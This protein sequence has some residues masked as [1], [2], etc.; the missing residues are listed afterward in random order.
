LKKKLKQTTETI[1]VENT[2]VIN[3]TN[4]LNN[5]NSSNE[6]FGHNWTYTTNTESIIAEYKWDEENRMKEAVSN[7]KTV[8]FLYNA[9]G[10]RTLKSVANDKEILYP[11]KMI[12]RRSAFTPTAI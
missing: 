5:G 4:P 7:G 6:A 3:P 11:D 1:T 12:Q 10:E 9:G 8:D 2:T